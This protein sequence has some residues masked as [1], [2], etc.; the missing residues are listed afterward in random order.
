MATQ[1]HVTVDARCACQM[2]LAQGRLLRLMG[3]FQTQ[4]SQVS[5][6]GGN[7]LSQISAL[8]DRSLKPPT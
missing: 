3:L 5:N 1:F 8:A 4:V 6:R 2:A 7:S